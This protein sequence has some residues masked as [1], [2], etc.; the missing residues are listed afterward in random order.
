MYNEEDRL[1]VRQVRSKTMD[2]VTNDPHTGVLLP[3]DHW[4]DAFRQRRG[5]PKE[6]LGI[7][8]QALQSYPTAPALWARLAQVQLDLRNYDEAEWAAWQATRLDET[9]FESWYMLGIVRAARG[10]IC[11]AIA[12]HEQL[13]E[14]APGDSTALNALAHDLTIAGHPDRAL[15]IFEALQTHEPEV[16]KFEV[17][18]SRA[19]I[20]LGRLTEAQRH[21]EHVIGLRPELSEPHR[22]SAEVHDLL[23]RHEAWVYHAHQAYLLRPDLP[24]NIQWEVRALVAEDKVE[25]AVGLLHRGLDQNLEAY[26]LYVDLARVYQSQGEYDSALALLGRAAELAPFHG[27]VIAEQVRVACELNQP[28]DWSDR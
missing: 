21:L 12:A 5:Q 18:L 14:L 13:L 16:T 8:Q 7:L 23:R 22:L 28:V 17:G 1:G 11:E 24:A 19:L 3:L 4:L 9:D 20:G 2:S 25:E 26:L 6:E 27:E 10:K 15:P